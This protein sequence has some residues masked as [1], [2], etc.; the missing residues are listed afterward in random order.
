MTYVVKK[1]DGSIASGLSVTANVS[2]TDV[3][4][5]TD[6]QG[7]VHFSPD[8]DVSNF[9]PV[10][11]QFA[12]LQCDSDV[13]AIACHVFFHFVVCRAA[14]QLREFLASLTS[15]VFQCPLAPLTPLRTIPLPPSPWNAVRLLLQKGTPRKL[16]CRIHLFPFS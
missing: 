2:G 1:C 8:C 9:G 4:D 15:R 13:P 16:A 7:L 5:D 3:T 11:E 10:H 14:Y 12:E 6:A